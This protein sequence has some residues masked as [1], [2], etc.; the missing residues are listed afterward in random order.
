MA[1]VRIRA[2]FAAGLRFKVAPILLVN[3]SSAAS[4]ASAARLVAVFT[5]PVAIIGQ[6]PRGRRCMDCPEDR[7][8]PPICFGM[9]PTC[10]PGVVAT[11][12]RNTVAPAPIAPFVT[13]AVPVP[14]A[15]TAVARQLNGRLR[16][17]LSEGMIERE[18]GRLC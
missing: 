18:R 1:I 9:V 13:P 10:A 5:A 4:I 16:A 2:S 11:P 8:T 3:I 15:S 7:R 14:T 6:G 17:K 12:V